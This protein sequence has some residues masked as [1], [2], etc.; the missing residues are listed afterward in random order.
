MP[1]P[2]PTTGLEVWPPHPEL[3]SMEEHSER[4]G[5]GEE[6]LGG[7]SRGK[8]LEEEKKPRADLHRARAATSEL[9]LPVRRVYSSTAV[10]ARRGQPAPPPS[11]SPCSTAAASHPP[12]CHRRPSPAP[13]IRRRLPALNRRWGWLARGGEDGPA[14][15]GVAWPEPA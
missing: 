8:K 14:Q 13:W 4:E 9:R 3:D 1:A 11:R 6:E 10:L 5:A 15:R 12:N 7:G 2:P